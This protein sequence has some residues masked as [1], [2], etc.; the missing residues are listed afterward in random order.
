MEISSKIWNFRNCFDT[1]T[2]TG[3]FCVSAIRALRQKNDMYINV[4]SLHLHT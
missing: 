3:F 1:Y 4:F 2:T